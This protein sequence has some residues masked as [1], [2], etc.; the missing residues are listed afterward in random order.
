MIFRTKRKIKLKNSIL[1]D[2]KDLYPTIFNFLKNNFYYLEEVINE[3]V[4]DEEIAYLVPFFHKA[5]QN[6]NK[7]NK[8]GILV[9]TYKENIALFLKEDIETEFLIDID[10][11]LTLKS[12]EQIEKNL[13]D[14][15]YILTTFS[16]ENDFVKEIKLDDVLPSDKKDLVTYKTENFDI[17]VRKSD[18]LELYNKNRDKK[19]KNI[20]NNILDKDKKL[21]YVRNYI[22][23]LVENN[24]A[25]IYER[26]TKKEIKNIVKVKY[27]NDIYY[28]AGRGSNYDGYKFYTDKS[29][30]Q[31]IM[32]FDIITQFGV[33]LHS[34]LGDN[35]YN[36]E[37]TEKEKEYREKNGNHFEELKEL[38]KKAVQNPN[39]E[40]KISY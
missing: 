20:K 24:K 7:I 30:S 32:K 12:F 21:D 15:D 11:I 9:T 25:V 1:K 3:K 31:E 13:D 40:Q 5:L 2:V 10:K 28:D 38:Y 17:V 29:L 37:L 34:S 14:Y 26:K 16:V 4:S 22:A 36:R 8:K 33:A 39:V 19:E 6:N 35:P 18:L 27:N 23:E